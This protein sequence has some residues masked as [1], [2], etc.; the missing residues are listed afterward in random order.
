MCTGLHVKQPYSCQILNKLEFSEQSS[1]KNTQ[2]PNFTKIRPVAADLFHWDGRTDM[3]KLIVTFR[4]LATSPKDRSVKAVDKTN[5]LRNIYIPVKS[6]ASRTLSKLQLTTSRINKHTLF[7]YTRH[8]NW[9]PN[10]STRELDRPQHDRPVARVTAQLYSSATFFSLWFHPRKE[11][12]CA[13]FKSVISF[14]YS[15]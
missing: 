11:K 15:L 9:N 14:V 10:S 8:S 2:I 3:T 13:R 1:E 7:V 4:N 12:F 6:G 5:G